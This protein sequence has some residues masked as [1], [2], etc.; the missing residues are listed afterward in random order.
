M[1]GLRSES[2]LDLE[3][4]LIITQHKLA[5]E[6]LFSCKHPPLNWSSRTNNLLLL[7]GTV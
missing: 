7:P 1:V 2:I 3:N 4:L 6:T 5:I